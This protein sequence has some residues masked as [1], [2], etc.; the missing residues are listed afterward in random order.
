MWCVHVHV[1][2]LE[3]LV[4]APTML[5]C[6]GAR[7]FVSILGN[8]EARDAHV[9]YASYPGVVHV[10]STCGMCIVAPT[11]RRST[12][13]IVFSTICAGGGTYIMQVCCVS[14][15]SACQVKDV[16]LLILT[17]S[18]V[19]RSSC[20]RISPLPPPSTALLPPLPP[21]AASLLV[22]CSTM[23]CAW[24]GVCLWLTRVLGLGHFSS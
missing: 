4:P 15:V 9:V 20:V 8:W 2:S 11:M 12:C 13:S 5:A 3:C 14:S 6:S 23:H 1:W 16:H 7:C 22:T 10:C 17:S 21:P 18:R 24:W 19:R